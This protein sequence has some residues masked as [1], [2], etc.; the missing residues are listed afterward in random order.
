M[1]QRAEPVGLLETGS[2]SILGTILVRGPELEIADGIR[3]VKLGAYRIGGDEVTERAEGQ[4]PPYTEPYV[5]WCGRTAGATPPPTRSEKHVYRED[6]RSAKKIKILLYIALASFAPS[7]FPILIL[8][9][10]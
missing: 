7:R 2:L 9:F 5:R 3:K 10:P 8:L 1:G 6:A 4:E